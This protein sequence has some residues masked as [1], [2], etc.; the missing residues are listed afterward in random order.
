MT[1]SMSPAAM[2]SVKSRSM[3]SGDRAVIA[4]SRDASGDTPSPPWPG[5]SP[6]AQ[7]GRADFS[8]CRGCEFFS[9]RDVGLPIERHDG[10]A[11]EPQ[12]VLERGLHVRHLPLV[13][14]AADL[15]VELGTL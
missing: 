9:G 4:S 7:Y 12:V 10:R 2:R 8:A 11:T 5:A 1:P 13:G 6:V 3:S 15:P 14:L